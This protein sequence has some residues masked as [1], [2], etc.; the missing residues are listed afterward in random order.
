MGCPISEDG[1]EPGTD[2]AFLGAPYDSDIVM[3]PG[4]RFGPRAIRSAS[5]I[6]RPFDPV[7]GINLRDY[8]IVDAGDAPVTPGYTEESFDQIEQRVS[9]VVEAGVIP[10]IAGG[11]HGITLP[12]LRAVAAEHGPLSMVQFDAHSDLAT[13][14]FGRKLAHSTWAYHA[15][16]DG[17]IDPESSIRIG[18]HGTGFTREDMKRREEV[19]IAYYDM[20][21]NR[22]LDIDALS[23]AIVEHVDG[24][25]YVTIDIDV[26]DPSYA[27]GTGSPE[28]G[29][30]SSH[31]V[32]RLTRAL[33]DVDVVG[34]DVVEVSPPYDDASNVT[35]IL[36]ANLVMEGMCAVVS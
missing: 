25:T 35:A 18:D 16:K 21:D 12:A 32:L 27:P 10:A 34:F 20:E 28:P 2:I 22:H 5:T 1:I 33:T 11:D 9:D 19:G 29:G 3:R 7:T 15:I 6:V 8:D 24:P 13:E 31:N 23:E 14:H 17:I 36:A 4:A 26:V 30:M